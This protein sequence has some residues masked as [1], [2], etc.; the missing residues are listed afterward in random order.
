MLFIQIG[1]TALHTAA[2]HNSRAVASLLMD[3][4]ANVNAADM[5]SSGRDCRVVLLQ[6]ILFNLLHSMT[7]LGLRYFTRCII[8]ACLLAGLPLSHA[9]SILTHLLCEI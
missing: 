6:S 9:S 7:E 4:H 8:K 5:V 1:A 2:E 3:H